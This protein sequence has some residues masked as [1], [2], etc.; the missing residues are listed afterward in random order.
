MLSFILLLSIVANSYVWNIYI[1]KLK[2]YNN[3]LCILISIDETM[4]QISF[5][6]PFKLKIIL[7]R[8][9]QYCVLSEVRQTHTCTYAHWGFWYCAYIIFSLRH[10]PSCV[11]L[12]SDR[13]LHCLQLTHTALKKC[14]STYILMHLCKGFSGCTIFQERYYRI[15]KYRQL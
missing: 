3:I 8:T 12:L 1:L 11:Y 6:C 7:L 10:L 4:V 13:Q 15:V 2:I 5:C 9:M 14:L